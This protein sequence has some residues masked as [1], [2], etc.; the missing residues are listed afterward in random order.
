VWLSDIINR[1]KLN[2]AKTSRQR[3]QSQLHNRE[4]I[5]KQMN[6]LENINVHKFQ[7]QIKIR[8]P[9][10]EVR[11]STSQAEHSQISAVRSAQCVQQKNEV[12]SNQSNTRNSSNEIT[13]ILS[14]ARA[15]SLQDMKRSINASNSSQSSDSTDS[16][17]RTHTTAN[18]VENAEVSTD[19]LMQ[20]RQEMIDSTKADINNIIKRF[21]MGSSEILWKYVA[22]ILY[23]YPFSFR[24][25]HALTCVCIF[26][27]ISSIMIAVSWLFLQEKYNQYIEARGVRPKKSGYGKKKSVKAGSN[28]GHERRNESSIKW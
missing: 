23:K 24:W 10:S 13:S 27:S 20:K 16:K 22:C 19:V 9:M 1:Q 28:F 11:P 8:T 26:Q 17:H 18:P 12:V 7:K 6:D 5:Q 4:Q 15:S 25:Y 21:R 2:K 14:T 3:K